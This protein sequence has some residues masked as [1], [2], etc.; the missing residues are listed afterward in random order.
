MD[1]FCVAI[2]GKR[3]VLF[4]HKIST[5]T[6]LNLE[7]SNDGAMHCYAYF[8]SSWL[9]GWMATYEAAICLKAPHVRTRQALKGA[10]GNTRIWQTAAM[11]CSLNSWVVSTAT[12]H[13]AFG[14]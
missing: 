1:M 10:A 2:A 4:P 12:L 3:S 9:R 5:K 8:V 7:P 13:S 14:V 11:W 6:G